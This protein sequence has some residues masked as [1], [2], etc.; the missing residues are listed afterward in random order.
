MISPR[1]YQISLEGFD[2]T[3]EIIINHNIVSIK[4]LELLKGGDLPCWGVPLLPLF[5]V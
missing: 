3:K 2:I 1:D 5:T 4:L